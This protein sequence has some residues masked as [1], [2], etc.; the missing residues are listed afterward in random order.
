M[1]FKTLAYLSGISVLILFACKG[2]E[3][4]DQGGDTQSKDSS[5]V[6]FNIKSGA[7]EDSL[8]ES[9]IAANKSRFTDDPEQSIIFMLDTIEKYGRNYLVVQLGM[10]G[11]D[12][13]STVQWLYIDRSDLKLYEYDILENAL[14]RWHPNDSLER[15]QAVPDGIYRYDIA[16]TEW[17]GSSLGELVTVTIEGDSV[18]V[19]YEGDG[20]LTA[21]K[22]QILD[23]GI[24]RKHRSGKWI[25]AHDEKDI[26]APEIGGCSDGP[27]VID[28]IKKQYWMC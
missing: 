9:Y 12:V 20:R 6:L 8:I 14:I 7:T 27:N 23:S 19:R 22:G 3:A 15:K 24:L 25:I 5:E 28:I 18:S 10:D 26:S 16:F 13:F 2:N 1:K 17:Q 11:E 4:K 21:K